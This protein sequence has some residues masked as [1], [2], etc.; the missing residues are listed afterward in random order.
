MTRAT[1]LL[2]FDFETYY[3]DQ[4]SLKKLL[5]PNYILDKRFELIGCAVKTIDDKGVSP[6]RW[7]DGPDF[8]SFLAEQDPRVTATVTFNAMFDNAIL[9]WRYAWVPWRMYDSMAM[10]KA[11]RGHVLPRANLATVAE[12]LGLG[13]KGHT[14]VNMRGVHREEAIKAGALWEHFQRYAINDNELNA[15]IFALLY[16]ELPESEARL[17]DLVLRC[18]IEPR[19]I[20]D[21]ELLKSHKRALRVA[22]LSMLVAS[23]CTDDLSLVQLNPDSPDEAWDCHMS[24]MRK[25]LMSSAEFTKLLEA[26]G[27][28]VEYKTS[29]ALKRIPA[30]AKTDDFMEKLGQHPDPQVQALAAARLGHKSTLEE[31]RTQRLL[32]V[33]ALPWQSYCDGNPRFRTSAG[34]CPIP[35]NYG[36]THTHRLAGG[37]G[38]NFQNLPRGSA[39]RRALITPAGHAVVSADLAQI[40]ARLLAWL[41][42][43][44]RML[45]QF[46]AYDKKTG[47]DPYSIFASSVFDFDV[48]PKQHP[49]HRFIGKTGVLGLGYGCGKDKFLVMVQKLARALGIDLTQLGRAIDLAFADD[50]VRTYR[51]VN[52]DIPAGWYHLQTVLTQVWGRPGARAV[53]YGPVSISSGVVRGPNGLEMRYDKPERLSSNANFTY[54]YGGAMHNLYGAKL[55]ENIIQF[56]ARIVITNAAL[57]LNDRGYRFA[58]QV[59]DELVF[60]VPDHDVDNA[61]RVIHTE[62]TRPPSWAKDLPLEAA[63]EAGASYGEAK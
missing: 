12:T 29:P 8:A 18:C 28:E 55:M 61:K 7:V 51:K 44:T 11:L 17:M 30:F 27:V 14:I 34:D 37:W 16:P 52:Y 56:L 21:Q 42:G 50:V 43:C 54:A 35:L 10:A 22:K 58:L 2:F 39:L 38:V 15:K 3:D 25:P 63:V 49:V 46:R 4:Y 13:H 47:K 1:R 36:A 32:D 24:K 48:D 6:S 62:L 5:P 33:A 57:R 23:G 41:C 9:A 40:E 53:D 19:F 26:R 31:T 45:E 59:H 60:I 20:I